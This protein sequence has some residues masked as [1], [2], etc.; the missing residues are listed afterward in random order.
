[1]EM[2]TK[3]LLR[4]GAKLVKLGGVEV[5][6]NPNPNPDPDPDPDLDPNPNEPAPD[7]PTLT[8]ARSW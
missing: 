3:E 4:E 2:N 7:Y 5:R 8:R 1:M 6:P